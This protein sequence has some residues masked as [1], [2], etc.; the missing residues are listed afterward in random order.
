[1]RLRAQINKKDDGFARCT[2]DRVRFRASVRGRR[3][4]DRF[5][6]PILRLRVDIR[7]TACRARCLKNRIFRKVNAGS[8]GFNEYLQHVAASINIRWRARAQVERTCPRQSFSNV[9]F[10]F[11]DSNAEFRPRERFY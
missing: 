7:W 2:N 3:L 5:R 8:V 6:E 9:R 4:V 11:T 10:K 1:M